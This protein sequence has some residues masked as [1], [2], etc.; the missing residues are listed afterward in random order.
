MQH[1]ID[2]ALVIP[3]VG[4]PIRDATVLIDDAVIAYVGPSA[5]A[6][7]LTAGAPE[8]GDAGTTHVGVLMP[9]FWDSHAHFLGLPQADL[10]SYSKT[11][12][13]QA[14]ARATVDLGTAL[15]AGFTS[16]RELGGLG[17]QI[18]PAIDDGTVLGPRV[19]GAGAILS[20]TGGHGDIH[21]LPVDWMGDPAFAGH[22]VFA[23]ADGIPA[24]LRAVRL[25]LRQG[26]KVIKVCASG[27]VL[28]ELDHPLHQQFSEEELRA[29]VE[30]A[31]RAD[32]VVAA[33]CHGKA[34]IV[35]ALRAGARTIEHGTYLDREAIDLMLERD[36]ILVPTRFVIEG[37]LTMRDQL[38]VHAFDKLAR[39]ADRH[40]EAVTL[41]IEAGIT[42]A[43]GSDWSV[44]GPGGEERSREAV[45]LMNLGLTPLAAVA[46]ITANGPLTVGPQAR[47]SGQLEPGYDADMIALD[48]DPLTDRSAWGDPR[49][50]AQVW[51]AGRPVRPD[52]RRLAPLDVNG[53]RPSSDIP[54]H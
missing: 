47:A 23:L 5:R 22:D 8:R 9:G 1:R 26:A 50:V 7:V 37:F 46:A 12:T 29:I 25:Q 20:P 36:A 39:I 33:H 10:A 19:Y 35:A 18:N 48:R 17:L 2:A 53:P 51:K 44:S 28:S 13:A 16:V 27:G 11:T 42:I 15:S 38:P 4:D 30:E 34:G 21:S 14:A 31:G 45:Y 54:R 41:A 40:A 52:D 49:R 3:G 24:C 32:R 6:P 43:A